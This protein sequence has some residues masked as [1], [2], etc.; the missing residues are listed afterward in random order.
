M[1][2]IYISGMCSN[3][4]FNELF[5]AGTIKKL[6]Q[7]QKYHRLLIEGI[8][9]NLAGKVFAISSYPINR[10]WTKKVVF[11]KEKEKIGRRW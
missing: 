6:P 10:R 2:I 11:L 8:R 7:A 5:N 4:K 9:V 1:D 3:R